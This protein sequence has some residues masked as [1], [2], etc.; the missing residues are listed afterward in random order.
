MSKSRKPRKRVS[1]RSNVKSKGSKTKKK[2]SKTRVKSKPTA[3]AKVKTKNST[4]TKSEN[5][6][7]SIKSA[8]SS[9][10]INIV[11]RKV[12]RNEL[13][14]LYSYVK[15][16]YSNQPLK[17]VLMN[18]DSIIDNFWTEYCN[19]YPIEL[20][21]F[22][23]A[24][25][26]YNIKTVFDYEKQFHYPADIIEI[27]LSAIDSGKMEFY[28]EE[29]AGKTDEF[30]EICKTQGLKRESP[31]P[32]VILRNAYCDV[33]RRGNVYEY[34]LSTDEDSPRAFPSEPERGEMREPP[35]EPIPSD[36]RASEPD[37]RGKS[38]RDEKTTE[39]AKNQ[40]EIEKLRIAS[41]EAIKKQKLEELAKLLKDG[42]IS[43]E[44]YLKGVKEV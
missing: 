26:W 17:Y 32:M 14:I 40:V 13:R 43:F 24:F 3:S 42:V 41:Q 31:P 34:Y 7:N 16:R 15:E 11:G 19:L 5:R 25:E 23:P 37:S 29:Y 35:K 2:G 10:Y 4:R 38:T 12:K 1:V 44:Q 27:D 33:N 36:L 20:S 39:S 8:I 30:Y 9:H 18:I 6:Y 22:E 28:A 21:N